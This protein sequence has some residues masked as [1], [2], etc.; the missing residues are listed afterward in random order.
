MIIL[1]HGARDVLEK[2][3]VPALATGGNR[4]ALVSVRQLQAL[5][6]AILG[7]ALTIFKGAPHGLYEK[8]WRKFDRV[9]LEF[10]T[11]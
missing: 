7:T 5:A 4:D 2:I 10:L 1:G 9:A 3:K 6:A 11:S 8:R